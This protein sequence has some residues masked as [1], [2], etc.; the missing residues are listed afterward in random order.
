[1]CYW[2]DITTFAPDFTQKRM[3]QR[4]RYSIDLK[5]I[6][7]DSYEERLLLD[8]AYFASPDMAEI[9]SGRVEAHIQ[10]RKTAGLFDFH[11]HLCGEVLISCDR[12]LGD[13]TWPVNTTAHLVVKLGDHYEEESE[14]V[15]VLPI[16][17]AVLD[18]GWLLYEYI[19]LS[20]PLQRMHPEDECDPEMLRRLGQMEASRG[21]QPNEEGATCD[22]RWEV[23]RSLQNISD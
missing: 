7:Q 23:L 13:L 18:F 8:D 21:G 1:M 5:S 12:C 15:L 9:R 22:T 16:T 20:L 2:F 11:F 19:E 6:Q 3:R 17:E 14:E 4:S 10:M